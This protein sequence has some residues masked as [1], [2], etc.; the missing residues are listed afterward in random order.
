MPR[1]APA[2]ALVAVVLR[3]VVAAFAGLAALEGAPRLS[4]TAIVSP[5]QSGWERLE[6]ARRHH[7]GRPASYSRSPGAQSAAMQV[8][9]YGWIRDLPDHRDQFYAAVRTTVG[10]LPSSID[11]RGQ[12]PPVYD[13]GQLG[14][15]TANA[16]AGA[17]EFDELKAGGGTSWTPSRLFIYYNERALEG[18]PQTDSGAQLR[19][20]IKVIASQGV[21]PEGEWPYEIARFAERPP[22]QLYAEALR[23]R[24]SSYLRIP[25]MLVQ[26]KTCLAEGFPFVFGFSVFASMETQ[27]VARTGAIPLP[28]PGDSMVGGHAV[29]CVGYDDA[30][31]AF[32]IRNS[33]G[34]SWGDAGYG[35]IPY[36]YL[37]DPGLAADF[38]TVRSAPGGPPLRLS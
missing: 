38:W 30:R 18:T 32:T 37:I 16:I 24:V 36:A 27:E 23:D 20:G 10:P 14:S 22:Q 26:L 29:G 2:V 8:A 6:D 19:D 21:V 9:G 31:Q 5:R 25:Q 3:F 13:Q 34:T 4:L 33:W 1:F 35:Y 7:R 12:C 17:L 15:C 28:Q 11:L